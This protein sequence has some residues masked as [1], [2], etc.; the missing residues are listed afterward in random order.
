[1]SD[2]VVRVVLLQRVE[3]HLGRPPQRPVGVHGDER[4]QQEAVGGSSIDI[5]NA[6]MW[7]QKD[8]SFF[9]GHMYR[10][11]NQDVP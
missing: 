6:R 3:D 10:V 11:T 4:G 7:F 9:K 8:S 5:K 2:L 1:M